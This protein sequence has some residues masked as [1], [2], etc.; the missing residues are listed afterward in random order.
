[1]AGMIVRHSKRQAAEVRSGS[2]ATG[3]GKAAGPATS[4]MPRK[5]PTTVSGPHVAMGQEETLVPQQTPLLFD[6]LVG[7]AEQEGWHGE[8]ERLRSLEVDDQLRTSWTAVPAGRRLF[9]LE[10]AARVDA[11]KTERVRI[12][13]SVAHQAASRGELAQMGNRGHGVADGQRGE[14]LAP[15]NEDRIKLNEFVVWI[16]P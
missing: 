12:T 8:T 5:Q 6:H 15:G 14:L 1:M 7:A 4:A 10:D 16:A 2:F 13:A 11:S 3:P 9:A